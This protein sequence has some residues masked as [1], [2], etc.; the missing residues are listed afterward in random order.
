MSE[1]LSARKPAEV[2]PVRDYIREEIQARGWTL[3]KLATE[4]TRR[5]PD[6]TTTI[7]EWKKQW[8]ITRLTLDFIM[9]QPELEAGQDFKLALG[10]DTARDLGKA[11]GCSHQ[12]FLNLEAAWRA[13]Q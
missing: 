9:E 10:E 3:D 5:L 4:M 2:F 6:E 13:G 7:A 1:N 12:F 8:G 11:F